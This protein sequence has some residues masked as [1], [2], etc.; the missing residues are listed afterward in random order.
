MKILRLRKIERTEN[1]MYM[2]IMYKNFM[3]KITDD[4]V[5]VRFVEDV[6]F[7]PVFCKSGKK[8]PNNIS[9]VI[10]AF[11]WSKEREHIY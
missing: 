3:G 10:K 7:D 2:N 9:N 8:L 11:F 5:F 6:L 4:C 1:Y